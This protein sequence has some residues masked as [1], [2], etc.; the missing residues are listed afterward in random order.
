MGSS[1]GEFSAS[2]LGILELLRA[3]LCLVEMDRE[4][5]LRMEEVERL[6]PLDPFSEIAVLLPDFIAGGAECVRLLEREREREC[7]SKC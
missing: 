1:G 7:N 2:G 3:V 5:R 6:P 4:R